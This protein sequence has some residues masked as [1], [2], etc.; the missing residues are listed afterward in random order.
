M[1]GQ[2]SYSREGGDRLDREFRS[3]SRLNDVAASWQARVLDPILF[4][5]S[6]F[7]CSSL[8]SLQSESTR[9]DE[10]TGSPRLTLTR[11]E[12][13]AVMSH[14][15][16]HRNAVASPPTAIGAW[17]RTFRTWA[18]TSHWHTTEEINIPSIH[19]FPSKY[20]NSDTPFV[21]T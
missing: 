3:R 19:P 13:V 20:S 7:A 2:L 16:T 18:G 1:N 12:L 9:S 17:A 5:F 6:V 15:L 10:G 11:V 14:L 8:S 4:P 21:I